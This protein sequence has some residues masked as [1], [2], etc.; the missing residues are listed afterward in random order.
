MANLTA[1]AI[2][3][4]LVSPLAPIA[5]SVRQQCVPHHVIC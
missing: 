2:P 1:F 5:D 4:T 3:S